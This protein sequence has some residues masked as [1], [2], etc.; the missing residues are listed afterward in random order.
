M[1][2]RA[3]FRVK[4]GLPE[5]WFP[6]SGEIR[7]CQVYEQANGVV[8][9]PLSLDADGS[10]FVVFRSG[11]PQPHL[12]T[13]AAGVEVLAAR[14]GHLRVAAEQNGSYPL[15]MSDGNE[16]SVSI[17]GLP[18]PIELTRPWQLRF[19]SGRGAPELVDVDKLASWTDFD[20]A[21]IKYYAGIARYETTFEVPK[22][23]T[24]E[25]RVV[26]LDL[27]RLWAVGRVSVNNIDLGVLWKPPYQLDITRS[28]KAGPN[29]LIVEV[30]NT[31][32]NRLVGDTLLLA[33]QRIGRTNITRSGTPGRP[34]KEVPLHESGLLGPVRLVPAT[35]KVVSIPE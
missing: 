25:G 17:D 3:T 12:T 23:W 27:G 30:A 18:P 21:S 16:L 33:E 26:R 2:V 7:T 29:R 4:D 14:N 32:S 22:S 19:L 11:Q 31:W 20:Q 10:L 1:Q 34:W 28:V 35:E 15:K 8:H 9:L 24:L 5:F 13:A 6:D